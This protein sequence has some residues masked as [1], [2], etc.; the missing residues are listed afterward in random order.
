MGSFDLHPWTRIGAMNCSRR[1]ESARFEFGRSWRLLTSAATRFMESFDLHPWTRIGAMNRSRRRK[2]GGNGV[3]LEVRLLTSAATTFMGSR[4]LQIELL[5]DLE[6]Q[7]IPRGFGAEQGFVP[8]SL[9]R[10]EFSRFMRGFELQRYWT[11]I[12][13]MNRSRRRKEGG[14]RIE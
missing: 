2:E 12:G 4:L 5:L 8:V 7:G 9:F 10:L 6:T 3:A 14:A 13:A 1:R 11:R